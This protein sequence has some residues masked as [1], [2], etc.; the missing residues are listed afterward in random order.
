MW[1]GEKQLQEEEQKSEKKYPLKL[2]SK[3]DQI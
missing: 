1:V 2:S 3:N